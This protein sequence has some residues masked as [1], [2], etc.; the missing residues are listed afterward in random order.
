MHE[1]ET[2]GNPIP[3]NCLFYLPLN[4]CIRFAFMSCFSYLKISDSSFTNLWQSIYLV[5]LPGLPSDSAYF[6]FP[7]KSLIL[8]IS[9]RF[10]TFCS[11]FQPGML[12]LPL[13]SPVPNNS[14]PSPL[15]LPPLPHPCL[16]IFEFFVEPLPPPI[17]IFLIWIFPAY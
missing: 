9:L 1:K 4:F 2:L 12:F 15:P 14:P 8:I 17:P 11:W 6:S 7:L 16:L 3:V 10:P 13:Y 5:C